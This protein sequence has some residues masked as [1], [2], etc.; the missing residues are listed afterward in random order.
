MPPNLLLLPIVLR[1][2]SSIEMTVP[3]VKR[4]VMGQLEWKYSLKPPVLISSSLQNVAVFY[5]TLIGL[6]M[7]S[8]LQSLFLD[9]FIIPGFYCVSV[10]PSLLINLKLYKNSTFAQHM[11]FYIICSVY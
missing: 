8:H 6:K 2:K 11:I 9:Y 1:G 7:A 5:S 4:M 10:N 3:G